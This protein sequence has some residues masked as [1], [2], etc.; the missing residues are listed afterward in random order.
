MKLTTILKTMALV[1]VSGAALAASRRQ[2]PTVT[3]TGCVEKDAAATTAIYKVIVPQSGGKSDIY[4]LN[5]PGNNA[6]P[7][8]V[9]KTARVGGALT[10]E[11][12]AGREVKVI[13]VKTF[14][15]VAEGCGFPG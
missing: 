7:S 5:A 12:R 8:A 6:V 2:D 3:V 11:K 10:T 15:V 1:A 4:Q 13:S 9:G 14:E